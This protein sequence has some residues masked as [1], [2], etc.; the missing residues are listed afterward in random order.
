[1][2]TGVSQPDST[3]E[4]V[5]NDLILLWQIPAKSNMG[6]GEWQEISNKSSMSLL[7]APTVVDG[8]FSTGEGLWSEPEDATPDSEDE[9]WWLVAKRN[10]SGENSI[11]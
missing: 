7:H 10:A 8:R 4:S 9:G 1:M 5:L 11:D 6:S 3:S 2:D